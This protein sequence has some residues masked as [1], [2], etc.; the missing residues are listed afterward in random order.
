[1]PSI[2]LPQNLGP[3]SEADRRADLRSLVLAA[4]LLGAS[5][6]S[7]GLTEVAE[8][9]RA[10]IRLSDAHIWVLESTS[11]LALLTLAPA[12]ILVLN[13]AP[14]GPGLW[15]RS[16]P[17]H[18]LAGILFSLAHVSLMWPPRLLLFPW[19]VGYPY[20]FNLMSASSLRY[21]LTKDLVTYAFMVAGFV[22]NRLIERRAHETRALRK[23]DV[24]G[25]RLT[26]GAGGA[27]V[28]VAVKDLIFARAADNYVEIHAGGHAHLVRMTLANLEARLAEQGRS[29]A[30]VHRSY[31]VGTAYIRAIAPTGEG[32]IDILLT[33]GVT[34]PG[35]RRY[36]Q[37]I[38]D[39]EA[40]R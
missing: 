17:L 2:A 28:V 3:W 23:A 26:L 13:R 34:I 11:H 6:A 40:R 14:L 35:S 32:D 1:M 19:V 29:H 24:A 12:I 22:A 5:L 7:R 18:L 21:E 33:N 10:G 36:R 16:T 37:N 38:A 9:A 20:T 8:A 27:T 4:V 31:L 30:R 39:F 25:G 15:S